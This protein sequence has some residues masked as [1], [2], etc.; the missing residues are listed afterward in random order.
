M[1]LD[2]L[3]GTPAPPSAL[4]PSSS[5]SIPSASVPDEAVP[6][7][8][9]H[10]S[11]PTTVALSPEPAEVGVQVLSNSLGLGSPGVS[12]HPEVTTSSTFAEAPGVMVVQPLSVGGET[13]DAAVA[14]GTAG[15]ALVA[16]ETDMPGDVSV[17]L[18]APSTAQSLQGDVNLVAMEAAAPD[19]LIPGSAMEVDP[20]EQPA[21]PH[22]AAAAVS[23]TETAEAVE[24]SV[25]PS[26]A[27]TPP[28]PGSSAPASE[29]RVPTSTPHGIHAQ[30]SPLSPKPGPAQATDVQPSL[31]TAATDAQRIPP[32]AALSTQGTH[33]PLSLSVAGT[34]E[35]PTQ[36]TPATPA[37]PTH[38]GTGVAS[39][40]SAQA[41]KTSAEPVRVSSRIA[42]AQQPYRSSSL[43]P[44]AMS[45]QV[46]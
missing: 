30:A 27:T 37:Q 35:P 42:G 8:K 2:V 23:S 40:S 31:S 16:M 32:S 13:G 29:T 14:M 45:S 11:P 34:A 5:T 9:Q 7:S 19:T 38:L 22:A 28:S 21:S 44:S 20:S 10:S 41:H 15:G 12:P 36:P 6:L 33:I 17:S 26:G 3:L 25:Q 43:R 4:T 1:D 46:G 39:S 24:H 18:A